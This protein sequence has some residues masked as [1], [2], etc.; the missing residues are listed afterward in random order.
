MMPHAAAVGSWPMRL[1]PVFAIALL[2]GACSCSPKTP[3]APETGPAPAP[4]DFQAAMIPL[5]DA[6]A[7][8]AVTRLQAMPLDSLSPRQSDLRDCILQRFGPGSNQLPLDTSLPAPVAAILQAHR[9]Y[10]TAVMTKGQTMQEAERDLSAE[11]ARLTGVTGDLDAQ[12]EAARQLIESNGL[13]ALAGVTAPFRE[14]MLWRQESS[15]MQAIELP[16]EKIDIRVTLLDGF[17]SKGWL[18]WATCDRSNTGGWATSDGMMVVAS[19]WDLQS[20]EYRISLLAH[21]SKHFSD[22]RRFL[23]LASPDLEYRAKLVELILADKTQ[24]QLL[25]AFTL[26][27]ARDRAQPH[28]FAAYW[29]TTN[30][31]ARLKIDKLTDAPAAAVREAARAE[32]DAHTS[33]LEAQGSAT[34]VSG[35]SD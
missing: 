12:T 22:Y 4:A 15:S 1:L 2:L 31:R 19:S 3:D 10:W 14:L 33:K 20:E 7:A 6:D 23:K 29:L 9:A 18:G 35:L 24:R 28:A 13:H 34:V 27:S 32:L 17:V 30:L 8:T 11:L 16:D 26:Q 5:F 25:E 21:E